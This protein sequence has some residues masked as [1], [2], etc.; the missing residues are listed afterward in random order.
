VS[1]YTQIT[2]SQLEFFFDRYNLGAVTFF[3]AI[4]NGI[5]NSNFFVETTEGS[6]VLTV[7]EALTMDDLPHFIKLLVRLK[8]Y[9]IPCPGPQLD[10]QKNAL[11]LLNDKPAMVFK[12]LSGDVIQNPSPSHCQQIGLQLAELHDCMQDYEFPITNN[13]LEECW[14]LF[15]KINEHLTAADR[16]LIKNELNFQT[17]NYPKDLPTG[18]IHADLFRDNVLFDEDKLSGI[19][20]FYS[21]CKGEFLFDI[22]VTVNDWCCDNGELNPEKVTELLSA[23][24]TLRPLQNQEKQ[25]WQTLLRIAA[26]RFWLSRL[27]H[28]HNLRTGELIQQKDPLFFRQL[29]EKHR[30]S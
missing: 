11:R 10:K 21:A 23:Y 9:H 4:A 2:R 1:V 22:A 8:N 15:D 25:H 19:L 12:R 18:I 3:E 5:D 29:L 26:M 16:S 20:D 6:F 24:E 30:S 28:Q 13:V 17:R 27:E 7:F 14:T